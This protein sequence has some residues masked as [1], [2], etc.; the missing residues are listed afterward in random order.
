MAR[1][2]ALPRAFG[3]VHPR[4]QTPSV[5][6]WV[7]GAVSL[8]LY[9]GL[10]ACSEN[11]LSDSVSAVGLAIAIEYA[12]T[13]ASCVWVFRA[14]LRRSARNLLLRGVLPGFGALFF[15]SVLVAALIQYADPSRSETVVFGVGGVAVIS[16]LI[17][18]PLLGLV[19]RPCRDYFAGRSLPR[20]A[21]PPTGDPALT[22][23]P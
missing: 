13:A 20:A 23:T 2:G 8:A 12:V 18:V 11:V 15:V 9:L 22:P 17:G 7:F 21:A 6:T 3:R 19:F 1:H 5:S 10:T 16:L 14:T 4:Y